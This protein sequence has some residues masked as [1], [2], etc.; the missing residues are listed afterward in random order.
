MGRCRSLFLVLCC[1]LFDIKVVISRQAAPLYLYQDYNRPYQSSSRP[2]YVIGLNISDLLLLLCCVVYVILFAVLMVLLLLL[3]VV[4]TGDLRVFGS[5]AMLY[6]YYFFAVLMVLLLLLLL[7]QATFVSL[8][9]TQPALS[10]PQVRLIYYPQPVVIVFSGQ[11]LSN[12]FLKSRRPLPHAKLP[13]SLSTRPP[14]PLTHARTLI[15]SL[16]RACVSSWVHGRGGG[17]R[18]I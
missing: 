17:G 15:L 16:A 12:V 10:T 3:I 4:V 1:T 9:Y 18:E 11:I 8:P 7:L 5:Y 2:N 14:A 6:I 13:P